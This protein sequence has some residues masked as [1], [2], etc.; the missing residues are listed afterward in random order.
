[1]I[2]SFYICLHPQFSR[3]SVGPVQQHHSDHGLRTPREEIAF[4]ARPKIHSHSQIFRYGR[5]IFCLP[6]RP[7]FSDFFDLCHGLRTPREEIAFTARPKIHSH[8]QIFRYGGS[9]FCLPHRPIFSDILDLCLHW[10][11]VV[12]DQNHSE[13]RFK[14]MQEKFKKCISKVPPEVFQC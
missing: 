1:M 14:N 8:S 12:R 11:S 5:S 13:F 2:L 7:K 3:S 6:H 9:I 4:T 10:V